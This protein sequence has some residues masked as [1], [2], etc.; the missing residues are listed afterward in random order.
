M[1]TELANLVKSFSPGYGV[2]QPGEFKWDP[3]VV[4]SHACSPI[5]APK[6]FSPHVHIFQVFHVST[7]GMLVLRK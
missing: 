7:K 2:T 1:R 5:T 3:Q 6:L 4:T